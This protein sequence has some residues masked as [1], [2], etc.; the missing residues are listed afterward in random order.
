[1][2]LL[3]ACGLRVPARS[4]IEIPNHRIEAKKNASAGSF[5][6]RRVNHIASSY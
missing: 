4:W 3:D 6:L 5:L 1:V 2:K